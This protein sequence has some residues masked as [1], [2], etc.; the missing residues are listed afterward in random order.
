MNRLFDILMLVVSLS[1]LV[2][3]LYQVANLGVGTFIDSPYFL[4]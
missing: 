3:I 4:H 1:F 2:W